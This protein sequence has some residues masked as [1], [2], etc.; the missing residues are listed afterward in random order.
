MGGG[1]ILPLDI[2][3]KIIDE[4]VKNG[5]CALSFGPISEPLLVSNLEEYISIAKAKGIIDIILYTN[6]HL[7]TYKRAK[8][9]I[10]AGLT[11]INISIGATAKK[12]YESMRDYSNFDKVL[13]NTL[14]FLKAKQDLNSPLPMVR[15]SFVNTKQN[16]NELSG[17]IDF[18]ID[19]ADV[20]SIQNLVNLHKNTTNELKFKQDFYIEIEDTS[21]KTQKF[22]S[23]P[24][25]R[26]LIRYN[27]DITPC[28]RFLGLNQVFGNVYKD[29]IFDVYNSK[30]MKEFRANLNTK[31]RTKACSDC[32]NAIC[33]E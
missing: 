19:K 31:K 2:Y 24:Y 18:W 9:L 4:G 16:T 21:D 1:G 27:G 22:C 32:L 25:Q 15:V 29:K 6:A 26:L 10:N 8:S 33:L 11:W 20:V 28:C 5:L 30:K 12:T 7:L 3:T 13:K 23:Q 17:F 14:D